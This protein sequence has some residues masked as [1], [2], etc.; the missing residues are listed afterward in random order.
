MVQAFWHE[1]ENVDQFDEINETSAEVQPAS[2]LLFISITNPATRFVNSMVY[3][4]VGIWSEHYLPRPAASD[5]RSA[6]LLS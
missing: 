6:V 3:A 4:G 2:H 1:E 5:R